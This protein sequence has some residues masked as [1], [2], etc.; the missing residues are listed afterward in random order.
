MV[1]NVARKCEENVQA[2]G[3]MK[4]LYNTPLL[5]QKVQI[6]SSSALYKEYPE[7]IVYQEIFQV[8]EKMYMRGW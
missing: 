1:D 3:K 8:S 6:H 7:W 2:K 4:P 5:E